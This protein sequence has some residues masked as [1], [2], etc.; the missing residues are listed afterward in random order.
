[1]KKTSPLVALLAL[2]LSGLLLSGCGMFRSHK[3]WETAQ[4]ES[5]LEIPPSLDRPSTSDALVIPQPGANRPTATGATASIAGV[6]GQAGQ[7]SDGFVHPGSVESVY[8]RVGQVLGAG[9]LGQVVSHDDAAHAYV[10]SVN[11][12]AVKQQKRGFFSRLF[13]HGKSDAASSTRGGLHR[14]QISIDSSGADASQ[15]RAQSDSLAAV[16]SVIDALK[17]KLGKK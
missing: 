8:Q 6:P 9:S 1:M 3:A 16:A 5:P 17:S 13:G 14:V 12:A 2:V 11:A 4:Q 7:I 15:V 10:V